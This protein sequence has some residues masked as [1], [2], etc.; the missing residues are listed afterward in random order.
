MAENDKNPVGRPP[1]ITTDILAKLETA[2]SY[3]CTDEEACF[4][5]GIGTT[6]LYEY[7]KNN[8]EFTERKRALKQRPVLKARET[9]VKS[10]EEVDHAKWYLERK[11]KKEFSIRQELTGEDGEPIIVK[12]EIDYGNS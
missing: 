4:H 8:P 5:A 9:V 2:F 6:T 11:R 1:A 3:D 12:A 7:Q 10:L